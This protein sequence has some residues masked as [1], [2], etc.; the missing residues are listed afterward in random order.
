MF[1][2]VSVSQLKKTVKK[3]MIE[4]NL[5]ENENS[6]Y[7]KKEGMVAVTIKCNNED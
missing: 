1:F 6:H 2:Q 4:M 5:S 3:K 7:I